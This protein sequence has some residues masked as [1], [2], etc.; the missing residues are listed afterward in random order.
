MMRNWWSGYRENS[1]KNR[2]LIYVSINIHFDDIVWPPN[3]IAMLRMRPIP[4]RWPPFRRFSERKWKISL[5]TGQTSR[6]TQNIEFIYLFRLDELWMEME[7]FRVCLVRA[8]AANC[9]RAYVPTHTHTHIGCTMGV[10]CF[11][12]YF[13]SVRVFGSKK[14]N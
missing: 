5:F 8:Q 1:F 13:S 2:P 4:A 7:V 3:T 14:W 11:V 10:L 9:V 12:F 6:H